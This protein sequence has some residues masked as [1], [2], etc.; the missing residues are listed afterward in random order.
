MRGSHAAIATQRGKRKWGKRKRLVGAAC[1]DAQASSSQPRPL[2]LP[3][4]SSAS[5]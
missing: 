5:S 1:T 3:L 4:A 2:P